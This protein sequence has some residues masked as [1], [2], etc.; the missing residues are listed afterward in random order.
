MHAKHTNNLIWTKSNNQ[1]ELFKN[2][3]RYILGLP[4]PRRTVNLKLSQPITT[5]MSTLSRVV[6]FTK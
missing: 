3:A 1:N 4:L 6:T 2:H 5:E